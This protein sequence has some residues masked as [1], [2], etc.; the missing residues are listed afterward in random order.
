MEKFHMASSLEGK[1]SNVALIT[2]TVSSHRDL[3]IL[4]E[5][6]NRSDY[7]TALGTCTTHGYLQASVE[8]LV[9]H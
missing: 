9:H 1:H 6:R 2:R 3:E 5:A 7:L 4:R 8:V